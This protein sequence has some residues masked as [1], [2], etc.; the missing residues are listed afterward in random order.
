MEVHD[1]LISVNEGPDALI[2]IHDIS[3]G[4][5]SHLVRLYLLRKENDEH[6]IDD[7]VEA[8]AFPKS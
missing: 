4:E 6:V 8:F 5:I 3:P 1:L 7:Q 2:M